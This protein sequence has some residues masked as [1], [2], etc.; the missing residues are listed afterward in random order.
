ML[1]KITHSEARV[2]VLE[3]TVAALIAQLPQESLQEVAGMLAYLAG[4]SDAAEAV[5]GEEGSPGYVREWA[6]RMLERVMVSRKSSSRASRARTTTAVD[7]A[8]AGPELLA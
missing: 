7:L 2:L 4:A 5:A 8:P 6:T 1:I 3:T